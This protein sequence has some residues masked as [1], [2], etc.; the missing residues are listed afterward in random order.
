[1]QQDQ[2]WGG[3]KMGGSK[4]ESWKGQQGQKSMQEVQNV[5]GSQ[6][7]WV[8]WLREPCVAVLNISITDWVS[9]KMLLIQ[10]PKDFYK[11]SVSLSL[12]AAQ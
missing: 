2:Q 5:K 8:K 1:M 6:C 12:A 10:T 9:M 11:T 3:E 7:E 4:D